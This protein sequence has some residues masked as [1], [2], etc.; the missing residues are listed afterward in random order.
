MPIPMKPIPGARVFTSLKPF[1]QAKPIAP[2]KPPVP[3]KPIVPAKKSIP[4]TKPSS[5]KYT[6]QKTMA[7]GLSVTHTGEV[8]D[9]SADLYQI[10][11]YIA[12]CITCG[13]QARVAGKGDA[14][15]LIQGHVGNYE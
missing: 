1:T 9:N 14:I 5:T 8:I 6:G 2:S 7:G 12:S 15:S 13:W 10:L 3:L 11:P 4:I